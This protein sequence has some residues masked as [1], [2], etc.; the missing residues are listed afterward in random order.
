MAMVLH[1]LATNSTKHGAL[2]VSTGKVKIS[3]T[4]NKDRFALIWQES[5]G[6]PVLG[7]PEHEG[8]GSLLMRQSVV[9]HLGGELNF[10]WESAGLAV[11]FSFPV[12]RL[13]Q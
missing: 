12:E 4:I 1:E 6:P 3:W 10:A 7:L 2:S 13:K 9:T 8:F 5:D 11:N